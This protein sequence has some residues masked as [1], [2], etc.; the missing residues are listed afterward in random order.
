MSPRSRNSRKRREKF[1][2]RSKRHRPGRVHNIPSF[3]LNND[4]CE[5]TY[6]SLKRQGRGP[7]E[8]KINGRIL[9]T[10]QAEADWRA[11]MEAET[12]AAA[13]RKAAPAEANTAT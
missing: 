13:S 10:E 7:R 2:E 3:C 1:V 5:S 11:A 12:M 8:I 6:F 4:I 9:I